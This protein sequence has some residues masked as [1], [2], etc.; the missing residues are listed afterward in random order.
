VIRTLRR[1]EAPSNK[2]GKHR[3]QL[4]HLEP[5]NRFSRNLRSEP[6]QTPCGVCFWG[7]ADAG[8][9][10]TPSRLLSHSRH[11]VMHLTWRLAIG[12]S[13]QCSNRSVMAKRPIERPNARARVQT[14]NAPPRSGV[15]T[16][17]DRSATWGFQDRLSPA[18]CRIQLV[19]AFDHPKCARARRGPNFRPYHCGVFGLTLNHF[20][21]SP[22]V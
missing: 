11:W 21:G 3:N 8:S 19:A 18:V 16:R 17:R 1:S 10:S 9:A 4:Y 14:E 5:K 20:S 22:I 12:V 6:Y 7:R 2:N 13:A 15:K